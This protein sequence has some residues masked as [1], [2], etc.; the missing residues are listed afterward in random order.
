VAGLVVMSA[1]VAIG[2]AIQGTIGFGFALVAVPVIALMRPG[3]VPVAI[4]CL[5]LPMTIGMALHEHAHADLRG[6]GWILLGR[7]VGTAAGIGI[8]V[9]LSTAW[10]QAAVGVLIL[11]AVGLSAI[12]LDVRPTPAV[13]GGAGFVSGVMGTTSAIGGPALA[14]V[15][16]HRPGP[17][18]RATL[19]LVFVVGSLVS[20]AGL[21][22]VGEIRARTVVLA[23][24][25]LPALALG[26]LAGRSWSR[27]IDGPWL[28]PT[29][30]A[31]ACAAGV[32]L[33]VRGVI[34]ATSAG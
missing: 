8:L 32:L 10:L 30:L 31:F 2:A 15:Y 27:R 22:A 19:A 7:V 21:A 12:G 18:L 26:L 9:S 24:E 28:R 1:A 23:L 16:Q 20:L 11:L 29:V 4:L 33:A 3:A 5:A 13:A 14:V 34:D 6:F 17:E 25:L